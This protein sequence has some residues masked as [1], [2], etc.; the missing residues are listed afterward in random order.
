MHKR[1]RLI[2]FSIC[3]LLLAGSI[4]YIVFDARPLPVTDTLGQSLQPKVTQ[5]RS[6]NQMFSV[7]TKN[8]LPLDQPT[9]MSRDLFGE[10]E[11]L[12]KANLQSALERAK[13]LSGDDR[14]RA[15]S[16][17]FSVALVSD[18]EFVA[19]EVLNAGLT[20][21]EVKTV[22]YQMDMAWV[23][24][25][26]GLEWLEQ[27]LVG[28]LRKESRS[29][30]LR[31]LATTSPE[32]ALKYLGT[33]SPGSEYSESYVNVML[34]WIQLDPTKAI[35]YAEN[36]PEEPGFPAILSILGPSWIERHPASVKEFIEKHPNDSD[37][38]GLTA[39]LATNLAR[40]APE[41]TLKWTAGLKGP[42]G[43]AAQRACI[44]ELIQADP[45][46]AASLIENAEIEIRTQLAPKMAAAWSARDVVSAADWVSGFPAKEQIPMV[47]PLLW[48]WI[49]I[50]PQAAL[51]WTAGLESDA[52]K[53]KALVY[54]AEME[55]QLSG[56]RVKKTLECQQIIADALREQAH[57]IQED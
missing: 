19:S 41:S 3:C 20:D 15:I 18:P 36:M 4:F 5:M 2:A 47:G 10:F 13:H 27:N 48:N 50:D 40:T 37:I 30:L 55:S 33:M 29:R 28:E 44:R 23:S 57:G 52:L 21:H 17:V 45:K 25:N 11:V 14:T 49:N 7:Q 31:R 6:E 42:V 38:A 46:N 9:I 16:A 56:S 32:E 26:R 12:A 39:C 34:G 35:A 43:E 54:H 53:E 8:Q 24:P 22:I 1:K 51:E